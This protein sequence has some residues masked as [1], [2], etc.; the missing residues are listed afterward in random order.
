MKYENSFFPKQVCINAGHIDGKY[1]LN[2]TITIYQAMNNFYKHG[3]ITAA[4]LGG[5]L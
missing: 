5:I 2:Y 3:H 1:L 4:T